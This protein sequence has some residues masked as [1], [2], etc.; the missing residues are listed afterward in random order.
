VLVS[1]PA[2]TAVGAGLPSLHAAAVKQMT[3]L[4]IRPAS[5]I[6]CLAGMRH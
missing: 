3:V 2:A 4:H 1:R 5:P 6:T